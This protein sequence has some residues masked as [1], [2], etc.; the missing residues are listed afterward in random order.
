M[1]TES[2]QSPLLALMDSAFEAEIVRV[3]TLEYN[4][5]EICRHFYGELRKRIEATATPSLTPSTIG[6]LE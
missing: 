1:N 4:S 3:S 5:N 6:V 2:T